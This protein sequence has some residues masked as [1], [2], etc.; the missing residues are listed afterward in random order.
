MHRMAVVIALVI[1]SM[2]GALGL[3]HPAG[4]DAPPSAAD[5]TALQ[6]HRALWADQHIDSY[7]LTSQ[8]LC[9]CLVRGSLTVQVTNGAITAITDSEGRPTEAGPFAAFTVDGLFAEIEAALDQPVDAITVEYDGALGIPLRIAIDAIALAADDER[10][11]EVLN[12]IPG[13]PAPAVQMR[14]LSAGWNLVGWT[15]A[16]P[17]AEA[18]AAIAG[19]FDAV[20]AWDTAG[21][22]YRS[23]RPS[24]PA[25][26]NSLDSLTFGQGIWIHVTDPAGALWPLPAVF[27]PRDV[28]LVPGWQLVAWTGPDATTL[29]DATAELGSALRA[30]YRWDASTQG[31]AAYFAEGPTGIG[32]APHLDFGD[33]VWLDM[34]TAALWHQPNADAAAAGSVALDEEI[35]MAPGDRVMVRDTILPLRFDGV[36]SDSRCPVDAVC[37]W[38]GEVALAFTATLEDA[39]IPVTATLPGGSPVQATVGA[40]VLDILAVTPEPFS[41]GPIAAADYRVRLR[42]GREPLQPALAPAP[43]EQVDVVVAES[44]PPQYFVQITSGLPD[45]C[46]TFDHLTTTRSATTITIHVWNRTP[47]PASGLACALLYGTEEHNVALGSDFT[48]GITY[49][50]QVNDVTTS[51]RAQ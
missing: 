27:A 11:I 43:I 39:T 33:G 51:F 30:A 24:A 22:T 25:D 46:H 5:R 6:T 1:V 47:P 15:G 13:T 45:S 20:F 29:A 7:T 37:V 32:P 48:P 18:T 21:G 10:T 44:F 8:L 41:D 38:A 49:T 16:A 42:V 28:A 36:E 2:V 14:S 31:F 19:Q 40:F 23:Y 35:T 9:F 34:H 12:F 50:L 17:I 26:L 4:A 3:L